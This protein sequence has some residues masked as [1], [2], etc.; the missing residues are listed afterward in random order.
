MKLPGKSINKKVIEGILEEA[1]E[2]QDGE[3]QTGSKAG[4]DHKM[5][6]SLDSALS[7]G[8]GN[9]CEATYFK[10]GKLAVWWMFEK[11]ED[12]RISGTMFSEN[13]TQESTPIL[14]YVDKYAKSVEELFMVFTINTEIGGKQTIGTVRGIAEVIFPSANMLEVVLNT[15]I[16][17]DL[18]RARPKYRVKDGK[19]NINEEGILHWASNKSWLMPSEIEGVRNET[20]SSSLSAPYQILGS[21]IASNASTVGE[22]TG[23]L[24][25]QAVETNR[26]NRSSISQM[27]QEWGINMESMML[28]VL[29]RC[30]NFDV[31]N[32][33]SGVNSIKRFRNRLKEAKIDPKIISKWENGGFKYLRVDVNHPTDDDETVQWL[34]TNLQNL[35]PQTRN[36]ALGMILT[37][38]SKDPRLQEKLIGSQITISNSQKAV[39]QNES[40]TIFIRAFTGEVLEPNPSDVHEDH[41]P[42][43]FKDLAG[44]LMMNEVEP[45]K[46]TDLV[47]FNGLVLHC[48]EHLKIMFQNPT[49]QKVA[50]QFV[51]ELDQFAAAAKQIQG[52]IQQQQEQEQQQ[53]SSLTPMEQHK[54]QLDQAKL[55]LEQAELTLKGMKFG[56]DTKK[57]ENLVANR[58]R[59]ADAGEDRQTVQAAATVANLRLKVADLEAKRS[60][61]LRQEQTAAAEAAASAP[62]PPPPPPPAPTPPFDADL[63]TPIFTE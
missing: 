36:T 46:M 53:Q 39:A 44:M 4:V 60:M 41:I 61:M 5:E 10:D 11:R 22:N 18:D 37:K 19:E 58:N 17:G 43:H 51:Q 27:V 20:S 63:T 28:M 31:K 59:R 52:L 15:L 16:D 12:G 38:V 23:Q 32:N 62:P 40:Q 34:S 24:R 55:Q 9:G 21:N 49:T 47:K 2:S 57:E 7:G 54:I 6:G 56:L 33:V 35:P 13:S 14:A 1:K 26:Q 29:Y 25:V 8:V 45:W 30:F 42:E 48:G 50:K 3:I